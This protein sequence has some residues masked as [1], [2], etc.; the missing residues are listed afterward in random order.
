MAPLLLGDAV[1]DYLHRGRVERGLSEHTLDAYER[2]LHGFT[3]FA[4]KLGVRAIREVDR[5]IVRRYVA[6]LTT[7]GYAASTVGRR[8]SAVRAFLDDAAERG[9]LPANPAAGVAQPKQ[10]STLPRAI[11]ARALA[12]MLDGLDG[13]DPV[14]VRDRALLEMLYGL[15]LRVSELVA[16]RTTDPLDGD[17]LKV[18]GKGAKD[19]TVPIGGSARRALDRYLHSGRAELEGDATGDALWLGVRGRALDDRGVRRVVRRCLGSYPHALRHSFATHLLENG[20]D[21]RSVQD[22][23]GHAELATTQI[24]TAV[25]RKHMTETYERSHPRA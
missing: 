2:D 17:F 21:L 4:E 12:D 8:T 24:Y 19:R 6:N 23:L 22:L 18:R 16:M 25:T 13:D 5:R 20:A 15:G 7:R 10:P 11:P 9:D 14:D 1:A 3:D